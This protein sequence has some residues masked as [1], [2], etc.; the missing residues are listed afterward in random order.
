MLMFLSQNLRVSRDHVLGRVILLSF[1]L[2]REDQQVLG[3]PLFR[4]LLGQALVVFQCIE[5]C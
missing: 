1:H 2:P 3:F 4:R 5:K